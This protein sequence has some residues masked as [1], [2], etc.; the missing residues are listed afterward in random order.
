MNDQEI[1]LE[2]IKAAV[3]TIGNPNHVAQARDYY[4]FVTE[5]QTPA[6]A[7]AI[8]ETPTVNKKGSRK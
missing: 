7:D 1:R 5:G 3:A 8:E 4:Q 6:Q 2:C